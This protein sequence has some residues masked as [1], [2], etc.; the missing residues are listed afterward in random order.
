LHLPAFDVDIIETKKGRRQGSVLRFQLS[1]SIE[2][3]Y[4]IIWGT[5]VCEKI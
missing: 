4:D 1:K 5:S 3:L 2:S